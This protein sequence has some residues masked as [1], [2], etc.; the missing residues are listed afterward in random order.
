MFRLPKSF[1]Y[2]FVGCALEKSSVSRPKSLLVFINPFGGKGQAL[3]IFNT[4]VAPLGRAAGVKYKVIVTE[5]AN[6]ARDMLRS[7]PLEGIDGVVCV[8]GDGMFSELFNGLLLRSMD[9]NSEPQENGRE[10]IRAPK[11]RVGLIPG[12]STNAVA[13]SLHGTT[14]VMTAALHILIGDSRNIDVSSVRSEEHKFYR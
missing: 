7:D 11:I 4:T 8:G 6:H 1:S 12:G 2:F 14:D 9:E 10:E 13:L 5:R 3:K